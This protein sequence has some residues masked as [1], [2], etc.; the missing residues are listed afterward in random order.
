M[1]LA[2]SYFDRRSTRGDEQSPLILQQ[3]DLEL[4]ALGD[5]ADMIIAE[6]L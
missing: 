2:R 3:P 6:A 4:V 1:L 5:L